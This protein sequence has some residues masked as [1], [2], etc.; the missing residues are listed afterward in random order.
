MAGTLKVAVIVFVAPAASVPRSQGKALVQSPAFEAKTR[1][2]GVGSLT[3]T[4]AAA[5]GPAL[6]TVI[7]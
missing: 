3:R 6:V 1:P 4:F 7:V 2:V 5:L